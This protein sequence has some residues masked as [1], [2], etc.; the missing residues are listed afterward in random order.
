VAAM[1]IANFIEKAS[2]LYEQERSAVSGATALEMYV[3]RWV[4]WTTSAL[5]VR[6]GRPMT[7]GKL[8]SPA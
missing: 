6:V 3:R 1:T 8:C 2:R 4:R 5:S 7:I